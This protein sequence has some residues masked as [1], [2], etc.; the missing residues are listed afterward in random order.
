MQLFK[1][2]RDLTTIYLGLGTLSGTNTAVG[3]LLLVVSGRSLRG[4]HYLAK[5]SGVL[6]P[7]VSKVDDFGFR[8]R[9]YR[10]FFCPGF[11]FPCLSCGLF[12]ACHPCVGKIVGP[13]NSAQGPMA[14]SILGPER[15]VVGRRKSGC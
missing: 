6:P 8:G 5:R 14:G 11:L 4:S 13:C 10:T 1:G 12:R 7:T 3:G 9:F 2:T 15:G